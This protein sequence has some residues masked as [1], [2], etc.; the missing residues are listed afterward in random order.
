MSGDSAKQARIFVLDF[1]LDYAMAKGLIIGGG[2]T[3]RAES[4]CRIVGRADHREGAEDL[5]SAE[6]L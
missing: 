1:A 3:I 5:T 4:S 2:D 6:L